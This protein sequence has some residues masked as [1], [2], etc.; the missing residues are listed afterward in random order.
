MRVPILAAA[1][2]LTAT[3]AQAEVI[4]ALTIETDLFG[5]FHGSAT[6]GLPRYLI[7]PD[8]PAF[9]EYNFPASQLD[10]CTIR[11]NRVCQFL[12]LAA[13]PSF[14]G[15]YVVTGSILTDT[16]SE[17]VV[18]PTARLDING[19]YFGT[20]NDGAVQGVLTISGAPTIVPEPA[21]WAMLLLGMGAV[22]FA[23][24][25]RRQRVYASV[26]YG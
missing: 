17:G 5:G 12:S 4:Y 25:S 20:F 26:T 10:S 19:T 14:T 13:V 9:R 8:P 6:L 3:P 7:Q 22:G 15:A 23:L 21:T 2:L 18:F 24:R 11:E 16:L 1:L